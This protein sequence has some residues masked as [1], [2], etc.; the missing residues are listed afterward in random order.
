MGVV[1]ANYLFRIT[2]YTPLAKQLLE[3]ERITFFS[4]KRAYAFVSKPNKLH[5]RL[6]ISDIVSP[7]IPAGTLQFRL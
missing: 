2:E 6:A 1:Q 5:Y 3:D 4:I 7:T